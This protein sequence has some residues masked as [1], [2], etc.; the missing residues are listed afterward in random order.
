MK[1]LAVIFLTLGVSSSA[2]SQPCLSEGT[3]CGARGAPE[4]PQPAQTFDGCVF[5]KPSN[6]ILNRVSQITRTYFAINSITGCPLPEC[7]IS[8][9]V[10][11]IVNSGGHCHTA[12]GR[13]IG[14]VSG[15]LS[16][17][18]G[19][20]GRA[21]QLTHTLPEFSGPIIIRAIPAAS[22]IQRYPTVAT[23]GIF[24]LCVMEPLV[25]GCTAGLARPV[26]NPSLA[27]RSTSQLA[28]A[29]EGSVYLRGS[30]INAF[31]SLMQEVKLLSGGTDTLRIADMSLHWGGAIDDIAEWSPFTNVYGHRAG[32]AFDV[33]VFEDNGLSPYS[34]ENILQ[35]LLNGASNR[36]WSARG[37]MV[38]GSRWVL[39][40]YD[41]FLNEEES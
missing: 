6:W 22:C 9:Q 4:C 12:P 36:G 17:N 14:E 20:T 25:T 18:T 41:P 30:V 8:I 21:F 19:T 11:A 13:P 10:E 15:P 37:A 1:L 40:V 29:H 28:L 31:E 23:T 27:R 34:N 39:H 24:Y 38:G 16:G 3:A 35:L 7:D 33:V 5:V 2:S 32:L 26:L